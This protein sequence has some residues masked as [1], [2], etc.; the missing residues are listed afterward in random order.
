M[1]SAVPQRA[2]MA[3]LDPESAEHVAAG[4]SLQGKRERSKRAIEEK[5][6]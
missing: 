4:S 5:Q 1:A 3:G 2:P 6:E